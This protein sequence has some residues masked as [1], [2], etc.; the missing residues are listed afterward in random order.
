MPI[1]KITAYRTTSG[2]VHESEYDAE[3]DEARDLL[4]SLVDSKL[5]CHS[6]DELAAGVTSFIISHWMEIKKLVD[7]AFG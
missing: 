4:Q 5:Q 2:T 7:R 3:R 1:T 6:E